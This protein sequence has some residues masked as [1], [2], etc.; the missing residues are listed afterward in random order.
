MKARSHW[1]A[2]L[3][4]T[5]TMAVLPAWN[6]S[7]LEGENWWIGG[8]VKQA[9]AWAYDLPDQ[10]TSAGPS[11]FLIE[12]SGSATPTD[13]VTVTG[14]FWLRGDWYP[15]AGDDITMAGIQ[16]FTSPGFMEQFGFSLQDNGINNYPGLPIPFG[17]DAKGIRSL[18][19]F[20]DDVIRDLSVKY[21][22]PKRRY[23]IKMGKFQR[24]WGQ[25]DGIRL[26]DVLNAQDFRER[27]V[28]R[29]AEDIRIP[30]WMIAAD[31][32][33][34][35]LGM[36]KPFK[37]LGMKRPSLELVF[38]PEVQHS[39]FIINNPTP[40]ASQSGGLFGFPFPELRDPVSGLGV[41]FLGPSLP[42]KCV[43]IRTPKGSLMGHPSLDLF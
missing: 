17:D 28:L 19:D 2:L 7:A 38:I 34:W 21:T 20:N 40:S 1:K 36:G 3:L 5:V 33:L 27:L 39:R 35:K 8:R 14:R 18:S 25:S 43:F 9:Y 22:D 11:N 26:L 4:A 31:L 6:A 37:A 12:V 10:G 24:G 29:D 42:Q 41:P 15:D 23:S 30:S 16:D 13:N 32:K